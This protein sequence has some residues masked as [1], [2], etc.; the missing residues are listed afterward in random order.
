[1]R[2][3]VSIGR[4]ALL[5]PKVRQDVSDCVEKAEAQ[6]P[7]TIAIR[8]VQGLR[9]IEEQNAIYAQGR[10]TPGKIVTKAQG[11]HSY[12]NYGLA[13]D[14]ALIIDKDGNGSFETLSWD[15]SSD[16]DHDAVKDWQEVVKV[17]EAAGWEWGGRF[18]TIVDA[19]HLQKTFGHPVSELLS[20]YN[21]GKFIHGTKYLT[22]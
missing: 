6:F 17:F 2:D 5:H 12:H 18:A 20:M 13:I 3:K 15:T 8:I 7:P 4:V 14:F 11:G 10:T 22:L 16:A 1:M 21:A 19:P 9:T